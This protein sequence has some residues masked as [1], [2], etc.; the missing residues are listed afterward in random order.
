MPDADTKPGLY[1][2]V[3][4]LTVDGVEHVVESEFAWG[5]VSLNTDKKV[6]VKMR[7]TLT[8]KS[9]L[10]VGLFIKLFFLY[11]ISDII[12]RI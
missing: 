12:I 5:L 8:N 10:R 1:K 2:I 7:G 6:V 9:R 11:A 3:T 4:T